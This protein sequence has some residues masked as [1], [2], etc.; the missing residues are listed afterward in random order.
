MLPRLEDVCVPSASASTSARRGR[1]RLC[2]TH[3]RV[4]QSIHLNDFP[5][6]VID[7]VSSESMKRRLLKRLLDHPMNYVSDGA[8]AVPMV[9]SGIL[10]KHALHAKRKHEKR[11]DHFNL[12]SKVI[13]PSASPWQTSLAI[14]TIDVPQGRQKDAGAGI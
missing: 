9:R 11:T 4:L 5:H 2:I 7:F 10:R 1:A 12:I 8:C 6:L 3:V 13:L 14:R